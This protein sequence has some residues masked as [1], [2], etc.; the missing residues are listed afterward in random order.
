[1]KR[2]KIFDYDDI[3]GDFFKTIFKFSIISIRNQG[4]SY[5]LKNNHSEYIII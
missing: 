4:V 3:I 2:K 5:L 1:M